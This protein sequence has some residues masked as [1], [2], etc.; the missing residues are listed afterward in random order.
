MISLTFRLVD[1]FSIK[2]DLTDGSSTSLPCS[3]LHTHTHTHARLVNRVASLAQIVPTSRLL[4][5]RQ[6]HRPLATSYIIDF[7][8]TFCI[9]FICLRGICFFLF[10]RRSVFNHFQGGLKV[11]P[12]ERDRGNNMIQAYWP[13]VFSV[14]RPLNFVPFFFSSLSGGRWEGVL[15]GT[16]DGPAVAHCQSHLLPS[17]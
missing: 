17:W 13:S 1:F 10:P 11:L 15:C 16:E 3:A 12:I 6:R 8:S 5:G 4:A 9:F 14:G 2:R 7:L